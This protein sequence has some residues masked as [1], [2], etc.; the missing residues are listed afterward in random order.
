V[1][2]K[3]DNKGFLSRDQCS[4]ILKFEQILLICHSISLYLGCTA[5]CWQQLPKLY[6]WVDQ[7]TKN[8]L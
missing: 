3:K 7:T 8:W 4:N 6:N 5:V 1:F 2:E